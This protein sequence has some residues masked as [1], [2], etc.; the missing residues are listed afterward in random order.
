MVTHTAW[1]QTLAGGRPH[2][3]LVAF[4]PV[5]RASDGGIPV[6]LPMAVAAAIQNGRQ[7]QHSVSGFEPPKLEA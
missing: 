5:S 2:A 1:F 6:A 3:E 7:N 4:A